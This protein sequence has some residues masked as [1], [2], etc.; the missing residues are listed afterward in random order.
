MKVKLIYRIL[1]LFVSFALISLVSCEETTIDNTAKK[2]TLSEIRTEPGFEWFDYEVATYSPDPIALSQIDSL[3]RIK[4]FRFIL[5]VNPSCNCSGTQKVFPSIVKS[6]KAGNVPDS[7][8][9]IFV[10][11]QASFRH[12]YMNKFTLKSLPGCYTEVDSVKPFY[13]SCVDTFNIY[14]SRFP[15]KY[16]IEDIIVMSLKY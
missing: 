5:F 12:P 9:E 14:Q 11:T 2:K 16:R 4:K 3:W 6:L 1:I 8:I 10:M 7:A 15:N 13:Y